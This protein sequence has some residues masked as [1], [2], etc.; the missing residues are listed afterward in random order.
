VLFSPEDRYEVE[1]QGRD[2]IMLRERMDTR[3]PPGHLPQPGDRGGRGNVLAGA[4]SK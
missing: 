1:V 4:D 2:Y 3:T